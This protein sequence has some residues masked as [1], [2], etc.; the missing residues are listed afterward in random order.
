MAPH[1]TPSSA[2]ATTSSRD[3]VCYEQVRSYFRRLDRGDYPEVAS[4]SW[5]EI[6]SHG[7]NMAPGGLYLAARMTRSM[8]LKEGDIVLDIGCGRGDSSIFLAKHFGVTVVCFDLWVSSTFISRKVRRQEYRRAVFPLDLD[9]TQDLPFP[10]DYFDLLF[11]MQALHSFDANPDL[12]RR[13]IGNSEFLLQ[14]RFFVVHDKEMEAQSEG[15]SI[16]EQSP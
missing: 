14:R 2:G 10:D 4:Y 13:L 11:C 5:E 1:G 15:E 8:N 16:A 7:E 3:G 6:Y 12:L 9:A